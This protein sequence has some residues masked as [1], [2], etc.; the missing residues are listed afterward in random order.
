[1]LGVAKSNKAL[2]ILFHYK[3]AVHLFG[4]IYLTIQSVPFISRSIL[5]IC[6]VLVKLLGKLLKS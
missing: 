5:I 4:A 6:K 3:M 2:Q 1:M